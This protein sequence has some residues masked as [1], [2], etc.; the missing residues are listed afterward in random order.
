MIKIF[1]VTVIASVISVILKKLS[2]EFLLPFR[3]LVACILLIIV[4]K[5]GKSY[6]T[7]FISLADGFYN[8]LKI[9]SGLIKASF[10]A[11]ITKLTCDICTETGNSLLGDIVELGG[12]LM[13][14]VISFPYI[15][16]I[17]NVIF[18]FAQ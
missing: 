9:T 4:F 15:S 13:I 7:A 6:I 8:E 17:L 2:E 10:V 14:F 16:D 1:A 12:R 3:I 11:V 18:S 5:E